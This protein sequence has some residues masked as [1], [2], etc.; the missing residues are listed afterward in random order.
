M[1]EAFEN[2]MTR[3]H[4]AAHRADANIEPTN[5]QDFVAESLGIALGVDVVLSL[6]L[7]KILDRD[8]N[9]LGGD[10]INDDHVG[11][12]LIKFDGKWWREIAPDNKR[13]TARN[14]DLETLKT[15]CFKRAKANEEAVVVQ[16]IRGLPRHWYT[17]FVD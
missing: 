10:K 2:A 12:R 7:R 16:D 11:L 13:A 4:E 17:P 8:K 14:K 5:L 6:G 9:F 15:E 1:K 3:R